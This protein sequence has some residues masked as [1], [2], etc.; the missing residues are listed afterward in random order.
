MAIETGPR[1]EVGRDIKRSRT[2][3]ETRKSDHTDGAT[4]LNELDT[5]AD[6]I[7]AALIG[8][9]WSQLDNVATFMDSMSPLM[10]SKTSQ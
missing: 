6:T 4:A 10:P 3:S 5:R 1:H 7:S 8:A 2:T 9:F